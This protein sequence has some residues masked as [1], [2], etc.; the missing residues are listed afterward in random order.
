MLHSP[1]PSGSIFLSPSLKMFH[2]LSLSPPGAGG[3]AHDDI[4]NHSSL[5]P[6]DYRFLTD[7]FCSPH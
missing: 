1:L 4:P 2:F 7:P 6:F 5:G 3:N